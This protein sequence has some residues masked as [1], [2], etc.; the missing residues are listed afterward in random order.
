MTDIDA[1]IEGLSEAQ[2]DAM[3]GEL[4]EIPPDEVDELQ[5]LGLKLPEY[6]VEQVVIKRVWPSTTKGQAVRARLLGDK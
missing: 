3:R 4:A 2:K 5:R 1:I 6:E